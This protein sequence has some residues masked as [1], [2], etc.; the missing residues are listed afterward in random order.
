MREETSGD[1]DIVDFITRIRERVLQVNSIVQ[2][3]IETAV[4]LSKIFNRQ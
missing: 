4:R 1:A 2:K 3:D